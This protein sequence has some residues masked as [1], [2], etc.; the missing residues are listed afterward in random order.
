MEVWKIILRF[1]VGTNVQL[2]TEVKNLRK[3]VDPCIYGIF[4]DCLKIYI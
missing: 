2:F 4:R 1:L 3:F